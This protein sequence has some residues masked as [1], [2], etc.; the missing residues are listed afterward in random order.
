MMSQQ[1]RRACWGFIA[2]AALAL[3]PEI[4]RASTIPGAS[5]SGASSDSLYSGSKLVVGASA[6]VVQLSIPSAGTL[7][8]TWTD[9]DFSS[10]LAG[11]EVGLSE[12]SKTLGDFDYDGS[13]TVDLTGPV[14]LYATVFATAQG[15]MDVGLYHLSAM[16]APAVVAVPV[17]AIGVWGVGAGF[18]GILALVWRTRWRHISSRLEA[19]LGA[20][21]LGLLALGWRRGWRQPEFSGPVYETVTTPA[22]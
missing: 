18:L 19:F 20:G 14:M 17:P 9:L 11:L 2:V 16:F 7:T 21:L 22:A 13:T 1:V 10:D 4:G 15:S 6:S 5:A 8:L 3:S 12:A